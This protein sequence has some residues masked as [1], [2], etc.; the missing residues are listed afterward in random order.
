MGDLDERMATNVRIYKASQEEITGSFQAL[1]K[2]LEQQGNIVRNMA[3][4]VKQFYQDQTRVNANMQASLDSSTRRVNELAGLSQR[5]R[6]LETLNEKLRMHTEQVRQHTEQFQTH[7]EQLQ[8]HTEQLPQGYQIDDQHMVAHTASAT[9]ELTV[10]RESQ[11]A[12]TLPKLEGSTNKRPLEDETSETRRVKKLTIRQ[13]PPSDHAPSASNTIM[14]VASFHSGELIMDP[15]A[16][17]HLPD[18]VSEK[19]DMMLSDY[20]DMHKRAGCVASLKTGC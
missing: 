9:N 14:R 20:R 18:Q 2:A 13:K 4:E 1:S 17:T 8:I 3:D 19:V 11:A 10:Q 6:D 15:T 7:E 12:A 16:T 5:Q